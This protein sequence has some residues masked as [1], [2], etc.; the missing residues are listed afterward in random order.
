MNCP[1]CGKP[2][3][4]EKNDESK[5]YCENE[6]CIVM[7]VHHPSDPQRARTAYTSFARFKSRKM[8]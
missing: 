7:F 2:L 4:K 6:S 8:L 1:E 3:K 5:Y